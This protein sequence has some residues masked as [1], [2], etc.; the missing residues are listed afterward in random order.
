LQTIEHKWEWLK[1][2]L[3]DGSYTTQAEYLRKGA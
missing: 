3:G 1:K 2:I